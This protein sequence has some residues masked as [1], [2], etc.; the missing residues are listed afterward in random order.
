MLRGQANPARILDPSGTTYST[1]RLPVVRRPWASTCLISG[2]RL[3]ISKE[4]LTTAASRGETSVAVR[5]RPASGRQLC[6]TLAPTPGQDLPAGARAHSDTEAVG[7]L[8]PPIVRLKG[9]LH[10]SSDLTV[11]RA[12]RR[13]TR[14]TGAPAE[15]TGRVDTK[16]SPRPVPRLGR[17]EDAG[18][19]IRRASR[20][21]S[22]PSHGWSA[23]STLVESACG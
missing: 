12:L 3:S 1:T 20:E 15:Y 16:R 17:S 23:V 10:G 14:S 2:P 11:S 22:S 7:L 4:G 18:A 6:A 19:I 8:P 5:G 9:A 13:S 21:P